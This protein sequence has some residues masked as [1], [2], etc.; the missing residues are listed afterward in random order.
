MGHQGRNKAGIQSDGCISVCIDKTRGISETSWGQ[1]FE[2]KGSHMDVQVCVT[3][4]MRLL[5]HG[6][7]FGKSSTYLERHFNQRVMNAV[8]IKKLL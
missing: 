4:V 6:G 2:I 3:V 7:H 5:L 8:N 1:T